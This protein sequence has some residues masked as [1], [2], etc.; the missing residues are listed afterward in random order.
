MRGRTSLL[1]LT[2]VSVGLAAACTNDFSGYH[3]ESAGSG[4]ATDNG[5]R[6]DAGGNPAE[7]GGQSEGGRA[8]SSSGAGSAGVLDMSNAGAAGSD[9]VTP[10]GVSP[11]CDG[12]PSTCGPTRTASCCAAS[13]VPEGSY[14][15]SNMAGAP[16]TVSAFVLDDY[17][18]SVGR[19]RKFVQVF[20]PNM[21]PAGAGKNPEN[22]ALDP[23]WNVAWNAKLPATAAAL[24]KALLCTNGT[25]TASVGANEDLPATCMSWYE[26]FAF[27]VWDG[28]RLPTE[29]EWN[30][31]AAA[32][33]EE[34]PHPWGSDPAVDSNAVFCPASCGKIQTVG[35]REPGNG[36][37]GQADLVGN[38]WEWNLDVYANPYAQSSCLN[39]ANTAATAS[40]QRAFRG[41]SAGNDAS[42]LL[43]STRASRDP[44]DHNGFIGARCARTP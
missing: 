1:G 41:G 6:D 27:C 13:A 30:Y 3:L 42:Y 33:P 16:A 39:C 7:G 9:T 5:G 22:L 11:S 26:A 17:E 8:G 31:A 12:L 10:G 36:K 38:A 44:G 14:N 18:I 2:L 25:F 15:R 34:R 37:W 40:S 24:S 29:A 35:S 43:S 20:S 19:F 28:G 23:G 21:T 32:G 4:G